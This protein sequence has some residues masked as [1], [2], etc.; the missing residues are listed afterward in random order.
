MAKGVDLSYIIDAYTSMT[1][2]K[3]SFFTSFF[4]KLIGNRNVRR[5]IEQGHSA[6]EIRASWSQELDTYKALRAKYIIYP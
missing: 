3:S 4:D 6:E 5:M 1:T 2:G